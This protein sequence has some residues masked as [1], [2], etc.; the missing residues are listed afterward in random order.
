MYPQTY[1]CSL[2][3]SP[4]FIS[5][6]RMA[7]IAVLKSTCFL[8]SLHVRVKVAYFL[9]GVSGM[10][11]LLRPPRD[12]AVLQVT[13]VTDWLFSFFL[14]FPV[15]VLLLQAKVKLGPLSKTPARAANLASLELFPR[16]QRARR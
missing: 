13:G 12:E 4:R 11:G 6:V 2:S 16:A 8:A 1:V 5:Q 7:S 10:L 9:G 15:F 3:L 14:L